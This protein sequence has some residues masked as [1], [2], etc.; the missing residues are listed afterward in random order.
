[1]TNPEL[2]D[3][4]GLIRPAW[5]NASP[6]LREYYDTEWGMPV[7][8]ESAMFERLSLEAFQCGLS[9]STILAK[10][11]A[12]RQVFHGFDVDAVAAMEVPDIER[13]LA[14]PRIVRNRRKIEATVTNARAALA[15]RERGT[16]LGEVIWGYL[17][18]RTYAPQTPSDVPSR[19][20]VSTRMST[21]LKA[22]GF[23]FVGPTTCF[24]LM[25]AVGLYDTHL[26]GSHRRGSSGIFAPD[27]TKNASALGAR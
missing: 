18:E 17:P 24:A 23:R 2:E 5:A 16:H 9:W 13:L 7:V 26:V 22:L 21:D 1:M 11:D 27:G 3:A 6:L 15:L 14:D 20:E 8:G 4:D 10:R 19:D 12:F 25:E